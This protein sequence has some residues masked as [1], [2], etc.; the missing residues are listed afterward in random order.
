MPAKAANDE[1]ANAEAL[2]VGSL[3]LLSLDWSRA[4]K[5][6]V[7]DVFENGFGRDVFGVD[8]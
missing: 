1:P 7:E 2:V 8:C 4:P 5:G 6:D 3:A